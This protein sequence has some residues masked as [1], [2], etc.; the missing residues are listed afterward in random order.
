MQE[1]RRL[2]SCTVQM[3]RWDGD[4]DDINA[5][6]DALGDKS[7]GLQGM[8]TLSGCGKPRIPMHGKGKVSALRVLTRRT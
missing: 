6:V 5:I 4:V 7:N 8:H 3:E 1:I 2:V